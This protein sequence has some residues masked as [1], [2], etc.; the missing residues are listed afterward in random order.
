MCVCYM[1]HKSYVYLCNRHVTSIFCARVDW[2]VPPPG[3]YWQQIQ[4]PCRPG[5]WTWRSPL[6]TIIYGLYMVS[7]W[8]IYG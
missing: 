4:K 2:W 7:I 1:C 3:C 6:K 5:K 8:I